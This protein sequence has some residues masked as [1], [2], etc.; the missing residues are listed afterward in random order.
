MTYL[1]LIRHA[2]ST[3]NADGRMQ[4][5][6]DAPLDELGRRQ[7]AALAER[8]KAEDIR[9]LYSSPLARARQTAEA[10][11]ARLNLPVQLDDR[12]KERNLGEWTGLTGSEAEEKFPE[13]WNDRDWRIAGPPGGERQAELAARAA[14]AVSHILSA[15]PNNRVAVVTH[16]GTLSAALSH[17]LGLPPENPVHFPAGNTAVA[18]VR[19]RDGHVHIL[20]LGDELHLQAMRNV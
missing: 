14:E 1:Y 8:L 2:R 7:A 13:H 3:W 20:S 4:G 11:A 19:V 15:H 16:G 6:A 5:W 18:R 10:I 9:A 12:W 17:L